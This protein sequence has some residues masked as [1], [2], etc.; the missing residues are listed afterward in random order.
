MRSTLLVVLLACG[1][2]VATACSR[3]LFNEE[4]YPVISA[5]TMDWEFPFNDT[6]LINPRGVR[7]DGGLGRAGKSKTWKVKYGSVVSSINTWLSK[8]VSSLTGERFDYLHDGATDGINEAG[9]GA[10]LLY[11]EA[12]KYPEVAQD[13]EGISYV[14]WVRYLLDTCASVREAVEAMKSVRVAGVGIRVAPN[15]PLKTLGTHLAVEDASGDSAIFEIIDGIM[16]VYHGSNYTVMTND[17]PL[18]EMLANVSRYEPFTRVTVPPGDIAS[19]SRFVRVAFYLHYLPK[20]MDSSV[21]TATVRG[22]IATAAA[23]LGAPADD[24]PALGVYPTWWTS[25]TDYKQ[26]VYY[27]SWVMNPNMFWVDMV[28]LQDSGKLDVG[29]PTLHLDPLQA[30]LAGEVSQFFKP[31]LA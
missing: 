8:A 19:I 18:P 11:L 22:A 21:M 14:R 30:S 31:L 15:A 17:P 5:R 3:G 4:G 16:H 27:W 1:P 25:L 26:R 12:T 23:P 9:L 10:H 13:V 6:L 7:M 28:K 24:E 20:S 29:A 2:I